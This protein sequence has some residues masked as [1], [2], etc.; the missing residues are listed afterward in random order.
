VAAEVA[1]HLG[2]DAHN[3]RLIRQAMSDA[4]AALPGRAASCRACSAFCSAMPA[5][6]MVLDLHCDAEAALHMYACRSTGRSG[7]RCT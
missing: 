2:D 6:P 3:I 5:P 7:V 1:G 4:L